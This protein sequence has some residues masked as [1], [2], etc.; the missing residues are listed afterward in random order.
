MEVFR[1]MKRT[2]IL[3]LILLLAGILTAQL[4]GAEFLGTYGF[5]N[6]YYLKA[7]AR[8][9][10]DKL[11]LFWNILWER[12]KLFLFFALLA[13]TP[14]RRWL[15]PLLLGLFFYFT[16]FYGAACLICQQLLGLGI[17]VLS[18]LP[19]GAFYAAAAC[20]FL[21][22]EPP[23]MYCG[24]K[25]IFSYILAIAIVMLLFLIG[26]ILETAVS[27]PLLWKLLAA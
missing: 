22:L 17:F 8:S 27:S 12:G 11:D 24:K 3:C 5:L 13:A 19:H 25:Y 10:P 16:G 26:C 18:L 6:D 15:R 9:N 1:D 2:C 23:G 14:L 20:F 4:F 21:R 7:F